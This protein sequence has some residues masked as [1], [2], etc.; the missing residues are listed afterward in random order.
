MKGSSTDRVREAG[1]DGNGPKEGT[2]LTG[3]EIGLAGK[4]GVGP[5]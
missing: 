4:R 1:P 2:G 5:V 3:S